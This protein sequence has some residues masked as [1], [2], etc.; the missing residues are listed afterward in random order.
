MKDS[1]AEDPAASASGEPS[2]ISTRLV[3]SVTAVST[4]AWL[5][6]FGQPQMYPPVMEAFDQGEEAVG[7]MWSVETWAGVFGLGL[8]AG[9]LTRWSRNLTALIGSLIFISGNLASAFLANLDTELFSGPMSNFDVLVVI[10]AFTSAGGGIMAASATAACAS[11]PNPQ[12][13][14]AVT[15]ITWALVAN[16]EAPVLAL[17]II[18][19]GAAG[20]FFALAVAALVL[21]P[22]SFWLLPPRKVAK[23]DVEKKQSIWSVLASAP[24]RTLALMAMLAMF[25]YEIGQGGVYVVS[26]LIGE[27][28]AGMNEAAVATAYFIGSYVGLLGG[29]VAAWLGSRVGFLWP[30]VIGIILNITAAS[31]YVFCTN[32]TQ[33]TL[34]YIL[35]SAAYYFVTPFIYGALARLDNLGRWVVAM[36]A[37]WT[38]GD[39]FAPGIVG[40]L[41]ERGGYMHVTGLVLIT[42]LVGLAILVGVMRRLDARSGDRSGGGPAPIG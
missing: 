12:R 31:L 29:V 3:I 13:I 32:G 35:W 26:A 16:L 41:V 30:I 42:G 2:K 10:R 21:L 11:A 5:S 36:E 19:N 18:P 4:V 7:W 17:G 39:A 23:Q 37:C 33:F 24:N 15:G 9:P 14:F 8:M 40:T 22:F 6:I 27:N 34:L 28:Q 1:T 25:I 20:G 38:A